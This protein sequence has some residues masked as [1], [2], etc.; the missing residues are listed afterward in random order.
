MALGMPA[1]MTEPLSEEAKAE[2]RERDPEW[3]YNMCCGDSLKC[4]GCFV[5]KLTGA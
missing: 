5:D 3:A 4:G 2:L 1:A